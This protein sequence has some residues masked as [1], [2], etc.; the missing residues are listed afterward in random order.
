M[1]RLRQSSS[2][3][4]GNSTKKFQDAT[5]KTQEIYDKITAD[6]PEGLIP[7]GDGWYSTPEVIDPRNC[8]NY[9]D[10]IYCG[11]NPLSKKPIDLSI[12]WGVGECGGFISAQ[13][14]LGFIKLPTHTLAYVKEECREE[15]EKEPPPPPPLELEGI[16]E[17]QPLR[18]PSGIADDATVAALIQ[19]DHYSRSIDED[20][21]VTWLIDIRSGTLET[22]ENEPT[23]KGSILRQYAEYE[24]P[25]YSL[26]EATTTSSLGEQFGK[27]LLI[28]EERHFNDP[29]YFRNGYKS[30]GWNIKPVEEF[31]LFRDWHQYGRRDFLLFG[32]YGRIRDDW[33]GLRGTFY[34]IINGEYIALSGLWLQWHVTQ[35]NIIDP[36]KKNQNSRSPR[37]AWRRRKKDCKCMGCCNPS[38]QKQNQNDALLRQILRQMKEINKKMGVYPFSVELFDADDNKQGAQKKSVSVATVAKGQKLMVEREEKNAKSIGINEFP[39]Y[40]PSSIVEDESNGLLGDIGDLKNKIFKQKIESLAEL[41]IWKVKNDHEIFGQWQ[42]FIEVEDTDPT[43]KGNQSR[44]I[45]LPNMARSFREL[46]LLNSVQIKSQGLMMDAILKQYIDVA[47]IKV[48]LAVVENVIKDIQDYLDY[49]TQEKYFEV[50]LGIKIPEDNDSP[51]DKEDVYRFL[52]PSKVKSQFDD[53]TGEGSIHDMLLVLL[54]A[55]SMIRAQLYGKA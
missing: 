40:A 19:C 7:R 36:G 43:K 49:P 13:G 6:I 22:F 47:N 50:P 42:E 16:P 2:P 45:V 21:F 17:P 20:G 30:A 31:H 29:A 3:R 52:T 12:D 34:I 23:G 24:P 32:S 41:F 8:D 39:I 28:N 53:W 33:A 44:R 5:E 27:F 15:Y 11:G 46:I 18:F 48:S 55:A 1:V 35:L 26:A 14:T 51:D 4:R 25:A 54:D 10:S 37:I 9:P 38:Q